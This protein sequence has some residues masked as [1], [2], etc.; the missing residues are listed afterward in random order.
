MPFHQNSVSLIKAQE[1]LPENIEVEEFNSIITQMPLLNIIKHNF[2]MAFA[3][4]NGTLV[5]KKS[6]DGF[7]HG[8]RLLL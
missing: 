2:C 5:E 3:S 8:I 4:R 1:H 7:A 6:D